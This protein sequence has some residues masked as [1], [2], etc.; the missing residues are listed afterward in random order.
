MP[1]CLIAPKPPLLHISY[2]K[3]ILPIF[4][5]HIIHAISSKKNPSKLCKLCKYRLAFS[6]MWRI[7]TN[8]CLTTT[9]SSPAQLF[10]PKP[11][12]LNTT[13]PHNTA[14]KTCTAQKILLWN[15]FRSIPLLISCRIP[16]ITWNF[17]LLSGS[18]LFFSLREIC[19]SL[20]AI[21]TS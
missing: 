14:T 11:K 7:S 3:V 15:Y 9:Q 19:R 6:Y 4:P 20:T 1:R 18:Q 8:R 10:F 17:R 12:L 13:L 2:Q 16:P 21:K 5:L